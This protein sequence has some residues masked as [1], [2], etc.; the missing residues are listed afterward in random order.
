METGV[1]IIYCADGNQRHAEIA[2]DTGFLYGA[3]LP[4]TIYLEPYFVDQDW[5][6]PDLERYLEAL[7][8]YRPNIASVLDWERPEQLPEVLTWGESV[9]QYVDTVIII[10]KVIG[11]IERIPKQIGGK[12]IRLGYSVPTKFSGTPVPAWE[13]GDRPVHLLGGSPHAQFRLAHYLNV[14]SIDGNMHN[15][16]A[17]R[18]CAFFSNERIPGAK[19]YRWPTLQEAD[20]KK[21]GDGSKE[22]NAPYE[23]FRRSCE[24]IMAMWRTL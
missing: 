10:P 2:I 11:G 7:A 21:W 4:N 18:F 13:F 12:P 14:V 17:N 24:N 1:E 6:N 22:A 9:A 20:G 3:Q 23:A 19:H 5:R 8:E 16:M 15:K